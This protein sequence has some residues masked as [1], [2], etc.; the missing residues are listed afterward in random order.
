[1]PYSMA[2]FTFISTDGPRLSTASAKVMR[3]HTTKRNF[4]RRRQRL[5]KEFIAHENPALGTTSPKIEN[6]VRTNEDVDTKLSYTV[7]RGLAP[8]MND[9]DALLIDDRK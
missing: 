3:G 7:H 5:V 8:I 2:Q 6:S 9:Q 1:M 4:A